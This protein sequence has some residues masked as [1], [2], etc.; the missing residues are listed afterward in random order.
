MRE[1]HPQHRLLQAHHQQH[2]AGPSAAKRGLHRVSKRISQAAHVVGQ[3]PVGT[4]A[5]AVAY[6]VRRPFKNVKKKMIEKDISMNL[7]KVPAAT[8]ATGATII[9]V[10]QVGQNQTLSAQD[11]NR[12]GCG[13]ARLNRPTQHSN[14]DS[15]KKV[16]E[17][18]HYYMNE[19][20]SFTPAPKNVRQM[21]TKGPSEI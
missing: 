21:S 9:G 8:V 19:G 3:S 16:S 6:P 2:Q 14:F 5:K 15:S 1:Q 4:V 17:K 20:T 18:P 10:D 12:C 13:I 11:A 7:V